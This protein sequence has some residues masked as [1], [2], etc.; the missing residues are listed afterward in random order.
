VD[1]FNNVIEVV[2]DMR[3]VTI[4]AILHTFI[5][6]DEVAATGVPQCV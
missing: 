5:R 3:D 1:F 4:T 6:I 2:L